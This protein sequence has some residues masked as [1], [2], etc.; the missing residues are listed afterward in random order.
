MA[1]QLSEPSASVDRHLEER[2]L[3]MLERLPSVRIRNIDIRKTWDQNEVVTC[4]DMHSGKLLMLTFFHD[5]GNFVYAHTTIGRGHCRGIMARETFALTTALGNTF[6]IFYKA[7]DSMSAARRYGARS[8]RIDNVL[9]RFSGFLEQI[10]QL[11]GHHFYQSDGWLMDRNDP[12]PEINPLFMV[13]RQTYLAS[14]D[15]IVPEAAAGHTYDCF[16]Y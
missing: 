13:T 6:S 5:F 11:T 12:A 2:E 10:S 4:R 15:H 8:V 9:D 14:F 1:I 7:P 16:A 3:Q